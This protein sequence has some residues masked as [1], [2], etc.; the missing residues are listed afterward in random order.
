MPERFPGLGGVA[1][2]LQEIAAGRPLSLKPAIGGHPTLGTFEG[3]KVACEGDHVAT[4]VT[5]WID[6]E[7]LERA[8]AG[9]AKRQRAA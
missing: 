5:P 2:R 6:R 7:A 1:V 3:L 4:V 9:L 8:L